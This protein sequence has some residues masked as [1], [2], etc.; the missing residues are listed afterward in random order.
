MAPVPEIRFPSPVGIYGDTG[1]GKIPE[2]IVWLP[3]AAA[4]H[5]AD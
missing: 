3:L 1:G 4:K 2:N 5:S